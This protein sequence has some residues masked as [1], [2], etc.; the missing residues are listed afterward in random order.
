MLWWI[1]MSLWVEWKAEAHMSS[2]RLVE[3]LDK[4][5][6][7]EQRR[8]IVNYCYFIHCILRVG[9]TRLRV[10]GFREVI[11][12]LIPLLKQEHHNGRLNCSKKANKRQRPPEN[13]SAI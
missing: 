10:I 13:V 7:E 12:L 11:S 3:N 5:A 9:A 2:F 4:S 8:R 1:R 6:E